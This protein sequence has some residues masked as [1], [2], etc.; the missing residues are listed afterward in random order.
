ME[1]YLDA[2]D[3]VYVRRTLWWPQIAIRVVLQ[4]G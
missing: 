1:L 4:M 2:E 3:I